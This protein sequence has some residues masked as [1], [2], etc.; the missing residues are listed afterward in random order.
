MIVKI[1]K[2]VPW[3]VNADRT[4]KDASGVFIAV[5][6]ECCDNGGCKNESKTGFS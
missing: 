5:R 4:G 3:C 2:Y 6:C 1:V